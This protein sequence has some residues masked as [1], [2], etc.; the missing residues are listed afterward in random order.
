[1]VAASLIRSVRT[2]TAFETRR[3]SYRVGPSKK[4]ADVYLPSLPA[5]NPVLSSFIFALQCE[6]T[7]KFAIPH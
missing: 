3:G 1:M 7:D 5:H 6:H 2:K 4:E